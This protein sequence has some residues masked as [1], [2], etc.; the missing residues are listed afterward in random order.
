MLELPELPEG[1]ID[2]YTKTM[3]LLTAE[4]IRL[5]CTKDDPENNHKKADQVLLHVLKTLGFTETVKEFNKLEK[6]YS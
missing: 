2:K 1:T 4:H 5:E 3:D 6:W